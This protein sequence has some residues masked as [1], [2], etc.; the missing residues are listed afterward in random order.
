[1][2][3]FVAITIPEH[4]RAL[5]ESAQAALREHLG[6]A[7]VRWEDPTK[8]HITLHFLGD[9]PEDRLNMP[10][11]RAE[12]QRRNSGHFRSNSVNPARFRAVGRRVSYG[13]GLPEAAM[14]SNGLRNLSRSLLPRTGFRP[15]RV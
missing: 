9:V 6:G 3:L 15:S 7:G 1:M 10:G 12:R 5:L 2:R 8:F 14:K 11:S 13:S 4:A